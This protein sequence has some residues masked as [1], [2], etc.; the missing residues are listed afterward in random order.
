M[1]RGPRIVALYQT[2][3]VVNS[4]VRACWS[5]T[6]CCDLLTAMFMDRSTTLFSSVFTSFNVFFSSTSSSPASEIRRRKRDDQ[7]EDG[8]KKDGKIHSFKQAD[9]DDDENNT[10]NGNSTQQMWNIILLSKLSP[11]IS[12]TRR[13]TISNLL[14]ETYIRYSRSAILVEQDTNEK[15]NASCDV[16]WLFRNV[17]LYCNKAMFN[18][19]KNP[20]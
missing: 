6:N 17:H 1:K 11:E 13:I 9:K 2:N 5:L 15:C 12:C 18:T 14:L 7:T 4:V 19:Q 20:I 8:F 3:M 16:F 10:W